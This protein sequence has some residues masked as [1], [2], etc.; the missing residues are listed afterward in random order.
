MGFPSAPEIITTPFTA[1]TTFIAD[2]PATVDAG[3]HL[4]LIIY[5]NGSETG[6]IINGV[7]SGWTQVAE[8]GGTP[9]V[10]IFERIADGTEDGGTVTVNWNSSQ[11]GIAVVLRHTAA[12]WH[13]SQALEISTVNLETT[14]TP[15]PPSLTTSYSGA[16]NQFIC[17]AIVD[18]DGGTDDITAIPT[19]YT[20]ATGSP[21]VVANTVGIAVTY[22]NVTSDTE[23]PDTFTSANSQQAKTIVLALRGT[24]GSTPSISDVDTD[25]VVLEGQSNVTITGSNFGAT[26]GAG[27]VTLSPTN[28]INDVN[29]ITLTATS[30]IDTNITIGTWTFSGTGVAEGGTAYVFVTDNSSV[31]S[32]G[33]AITRETPVVTYSLTVGPFS[34]NSGQALPNT[35][36]KWEWYAGGRVGTL[37]KPSTESGSGTTDGSGNL[38][39]TGLAATTTGYGLLVD[40]NANVTDD[41]VAYFFGT[42]S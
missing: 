21:Y 15:N 2:L 9:K 35:A 41:H 38:T 13:G 6:D 26:Q 10:G 36:V 23:D 16:D 22:K 12:S 25:E 28:D 37:P 1:S 40:E 5:Q 7:P 19:G 33:F 31:D 34:N 20:S 3:D 17:L 39:I 27:T 32:A 29:A 42:P 24:A 11:T 14:T 18:Y 4:T 8:D 30:W